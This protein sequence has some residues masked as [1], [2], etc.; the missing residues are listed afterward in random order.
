[1]S[2]D[3]NTVLIGAPTYSD[4][5]G[6]AYLFTNSDTTWIKTQFLAKDG[7][8]HDRSGISVVL[9]KDGSTAII[10]TNNSINSDTNIYI[11]SN[12]DNNWIQNQ[13]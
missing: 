11:F 13:N 9:S 7:I 6:S 12:S 1:V 8:P 2:A 10:G 4:N 3:G 5:Q